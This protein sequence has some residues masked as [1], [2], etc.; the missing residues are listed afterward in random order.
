MQQHARTRTVWSFV[1]QS[2]PSHFLPRYCGQQ[3]QLRTPRDADHS[4]HLLLGTA[5]NVL[6]VRV[7]Q[8]W[9][10]RLRWAGS[11]L[12]HPGARSLRASGLHFS[13][14]PDT[15]PHQSGVPQPLNPSFTPKVDLHLFVA[16]VH[17]ARSRDP[18]RPFGL[19]C[20]QV[21]YPS[22]YY[23]SDDVP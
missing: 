5:S 11:L 21:Y 15:R 16:H 19:D 14:Q 17:A 8:R 10:Q 2:I 13:Q 20:T 6:F 18:T 12:G 7:T 4:T 23:R 1:P 3:P 22:Q 9:L